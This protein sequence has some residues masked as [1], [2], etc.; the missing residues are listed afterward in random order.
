MRQ[1]LLKMFETNVIEHFPRILQPNDPPVLFTLEQLQEK[2]IKALK[3]QQNRKDSK[4]TDNESMKKVN[5]NDLRITLTSCNEYSDRVIINEKSNILLGIEKKQEINEEIQ[6]STTDK[7]C[8][9]STQK[10]IIIKTDTIFIDSRD[11]ILLNTEDKQEVIDLIES[12]RSNVT[13]DYSQIAHNIT[14]IR[15]SYDTSKEEIPLNFVF[16]EKIHSLSTNVTLMS[17]EEKAS[18]RWHT[19]KDEINAKTA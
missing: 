15:T 6:G 12:S 10:D 11:N 7:I 4:N 1:H 16:N 17:N 19:R 8:V 14:Q 3:K 13:D 9:T 5:V 18:F 2:Q